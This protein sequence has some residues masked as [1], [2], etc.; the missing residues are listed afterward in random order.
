LGGGG[1]DGLSAH[2]SSLNYH[3]SKKKV[4]NERVVR[5]KVLVW[6]GNRAG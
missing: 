3:I 1:S 6:V 5:I 4:K 2:L